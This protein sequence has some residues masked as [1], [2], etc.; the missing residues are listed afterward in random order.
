MRNNI[1][2]GVVIC[3]VVACTCRADETKPAAQS[4]PSTAS[5]PKAESDRSAARA[6]LKA[7]QGTWERVAMELE[8][9]PAPDNL[10]TG[11]SAT[12]EDDRLTLRHPGGV[13]RH[14]IVT[15]DPDRT[16]KATNTWD[17][18]GQFADQTVPGIYEL[19]GDIAKF[20][21]A[22]PGQKRPTE[23]TTKKG[24]GFVYFEYSR[25]KK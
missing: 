23:F 17:L 4:K 15:L 5:K 1:A 25:K 6:D 2:F 8:G 21:F 9:K 10:I 20:C 16:P 12:Y 7:L 22:R 3:M 19:N 18:E 13:Y 11:W 14:S 24:T